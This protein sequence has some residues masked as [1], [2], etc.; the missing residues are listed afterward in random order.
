MKETKKNPDSACHTCYTPIFLPL[1]VAMGTAIGVS[2]GNLA[3]WLFLGVSFGLC[4]GNGLDS[5]KKEKG[6][7]NRRDIQ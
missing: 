1:G 5:R 4:I 7:E 3:L 6:P 2:V